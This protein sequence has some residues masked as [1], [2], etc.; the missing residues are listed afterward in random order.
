MHCY[1]TN[2]R[3]KAIK[4]KNLWSAHFD[5]GF[6]MKVNDASTLIMVKS[7]RSWRVIDLNDPQFSS[8]LQEWVDEI[9]ASL[10]SEKA[11]V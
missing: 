1:E 2:N 3:F 6:D 10:E 4:T 7:N 5:R 8:L 9:K 11:L